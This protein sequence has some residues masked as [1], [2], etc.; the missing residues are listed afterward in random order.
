MLTSKMSTAEY[1][2]LRLHYDNEWKQVMFFM[3]PTSGQKT[4]T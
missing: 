2:A 4:F 1:Y 3:L